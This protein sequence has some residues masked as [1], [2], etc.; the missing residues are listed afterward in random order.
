MRRQDPEWLAAAGSFE[1][2]DYQGRRR[3]GAKPF[4]VISA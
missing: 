3:A 4:S 2:V 1:L